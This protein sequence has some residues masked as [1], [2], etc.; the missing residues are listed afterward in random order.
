MIKLNEV[1]M[2]KIYNSNLFS[3]RL[4]GAGVRQGRRGDGRGVQEA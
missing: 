3:G 2:Q 4:R 1:A